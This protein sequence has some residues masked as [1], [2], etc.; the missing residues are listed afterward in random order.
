LSK[1]GEDDILSG[2]MC[3]QVS[4]PTRGVSTPRIRTTGGEYLHEFE[5]ED[6]EEVDITKP[7]PIWICL[8]LI[9]G[10]LFGGAFM[11][12]ETQEWNFLNSIYF[13]FITLSTIGFG[14]F[15]PKNKDNQT[16]AA[17]E[18]HDQDQEELINIGITA[19]YIIFGMSLFFMVVHLF[20][21][22]FLMI[23]FQIAI[24]SPG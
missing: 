21:V 17:L 14:D 9:F 3:L 7:I 23:T 15:V 6:W 20:Q 1:V 19:I 18:G 13:C 22:C 16:G 12:I 10:I 24:L 11:F 4:T 8:L 5:Y 2:Q